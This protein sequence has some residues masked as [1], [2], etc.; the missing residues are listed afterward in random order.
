MADAV[1]SR[2]LRHWVVFAAFSFL[3]IFLKLLPVGGANSLLPVP[4]FILC[5]G[6]AWVLRRP[7]YIPV[8]LFAAVMLWT[9]ILF[10]RP[11]GLWTLLAILGFEFLRA[12]RAATRDLPFML[13]W[14]LIGVVIAAM[15]LAQILILAIF[16]VSQ[17]PVGMTFVQMIATIACYPAVV[18]F[19][20]RAIG[21]RRGM[22]VGTDQIGRRP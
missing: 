3:V 8:I 1:Q 10:F 16:A 20:A 6:F 18:L 14:L 9:D 19:S 5:I 17:P 7:D 15:T 2:P 22:A 21:I 11:L 4:D 12:R 13:E